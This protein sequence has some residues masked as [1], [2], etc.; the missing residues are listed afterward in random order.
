[1]SLFSESNFV[2]LESSDSFMDITKQT[3]RIYPVPRTSLNRL[4]E[5]TQ[6]PSHSSNS[7]GNYLS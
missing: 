4:E 2:S 6:S 7:F 5:F 1:M 3:G